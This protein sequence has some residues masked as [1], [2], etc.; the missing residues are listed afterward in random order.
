MI[1]G[2]FHLQL[3]NN[4]MQKGLLLSFILLSLLAVGIL[5][6]RQQHRVE[7]K[8]EIEE[9][10]NESPEKR[11]AMTEARAQYEYD[12]L[13]DPITGKIPTGI[14]KAEMKQAMSI[15]VS[16]HQQSAAS[17]GIIRTGFG[18][19]GP[20]TNLYLPAGPNN[21]GGR[22]RAFVFDKRYNGTTNKVILSGCVS[23][24]IMRSTDGGNTWTLVTPDQQVHSISCFAQDPNTPDTW[25]AG[26]GESLG[27]SASASGAFYLGNGVFKSIDNGASW[28]ALAATQGALS[29]FDNVFDLVN[30][31][32]VNP[33]NSDVYV[34]CVSTI[35]RSKN[36]GA[37]WSAV[38]TA[39]VLGNSV[40]GNTD[41]AINKTGTKFYCS[42][43]L[44]SPAADRG[45]WQSDTGDLNSWTVVGGNVAGT[46]TGWQVNTGSSS[47]GRI[48]LQLAP[49]NDNILYVLYE[50]GASQAS[51]SFSP[52]ADFFKLDNT[53]G[54]AVWT[55]LSA[56]MPDMPGGNRTGSDPL[57]VQG[58]YDL[59]LAV[60]PDDANTVYVGGTNL[61]RSTNGFTNVS[62]TSWIG[63]YK[64]DFT[65]NVYAN[66][67]PDMH[68]LAF[69]PTNSK[70]AFCCND[71]GV[72]VTDDIT[73]PVVAW[74]FITNYQTL[75]YYSVAIDPET[76]KD[77]FIGGA[78]DNGTWYRDA[79]LN[80]GPRPAARA[81]INDFVNLFSGDGVK[82]D[83]AKISAGQQLTYFG[84]QGGLIV[85]DELLNNA[86]YPGAA[87]K[88]KIAD[89]TANT[90]NGYG[91]FVTNFK[92]S[93]SNSEVLFYTNYNKLF[94]TNSAS[95]VD[96]SKWTRLLAVENKVNS[97]GGTSVSI[98]AMNFSWGPYQSSHAMYIGTNNSK[99]Y[100]LD[101]YANANELSIP[102]DISIPALATSTVNI[103]D[104]AVNPNDD[105]EIMAVVS[106]YNT[107]SIWW[108]YDAKSATPSWSNAEGNLTLPSIR[109]C[110]IV[111]KKDAGN[112]PITEYYVGTSVGLYTTA[113]IGKTL[114]AGGNIVWSREGASVINYAVVH[115]IDYRPEDNTLLL[116]T[117]GNGMFYTQIGSANFTPNLP[118]AVA[119]A[120]LNDKNFVTVYPTVSTGNYHYEAGR[121]SGIKMMHIQVFNMLGQPLYRS[122]VNYGSGN[123]LLSGMPAGNY[124]VQIISDNKKYQ[125]LQKIIKQ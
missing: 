41:I 74:T 60:K 111:V 8:F 91:D 22:T 72:Q 107:V 95:T 104:I 105:N 112:N 82:V 115:S 47:W 110:A 39:S 16:G 17:N 6:N 66:S 38:K 62:A 18:V 64:T 119:P 94:K 69:D 71:G 84:A 12:I 36:G 54:T 78:Q 125:S 26:T 77:N 14:Y 88:P 90:N 13:K 32:V 86:T 11:D 85:R 68:F 97:L 49:S 98:R 51:P 55:N 5:W 103:I 96:S 19:N 23:G 56:N 109:S 116:G 20:S 27:N 2:E 108:T 101:D 75:Q 79:S 44:K 25:Y 65:T 42:F 53:G 83:I 123:I 80:F 43:H 9:E 7:K 3:K 35:Y 48:V 67:H 33:A 120:I 73:A 102:Q 117:H 40:T 61:Y 106:N 89:L 46:P 52:E 63:G 57:A 118:T 30:R 70:R 28:S 15:P 29:S 59:L 114:G 10:E 4:Q 124:V 58:G 99:I 45:V 50:N 24:G 81:G 87:I 31:I 34:A 92:L 21:V 93:N 122:T 113:S 121:I 76:G 100:R 1:K 37:T